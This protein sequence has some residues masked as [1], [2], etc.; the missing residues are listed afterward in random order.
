MRKLLIAGIT[1]LIPTGTAAQPFSDSMADCAAIYQNAAQWVETDEAADRLMLAATRWAEAAITQARAEGV[2]QAENS[3]WT[4][5][6]NKTDQWEEKGQTVFFS[7][8]FRDW[9]QYCRAFAKDR[10]IAIER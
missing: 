4:H 5:I 3:V 2:V 1:L 6:D 10:G 8:E 7:Q 9:T